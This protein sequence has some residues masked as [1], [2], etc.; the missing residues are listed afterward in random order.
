M[1]SFAVY[2]K[3]FLN[4]E[5]K[6]LLAEYDF[7]LV[8]VEFRQDFLKSVDIVDLRF[9]NMYG[10][11]ETMMGLSLRIDPR[12]KHYLLDK[13]EYE[14]KKARADLGPSRKTS[15]RGA[16]LTFS[17]INE[18]MYGPPMDDTPKHKPTKKKKIDRTKC[19]YFKVMTNG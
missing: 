9:D 15:I 12:Y 1:S 3:T 14:I 7:H 17:Y 5:I 11:R 6:E 19:S 8:A 4:R 10:S 18:Y 2:E 16:P 13:I